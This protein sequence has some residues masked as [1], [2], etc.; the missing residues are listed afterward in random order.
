MRAAGIQNAGKSFGRKTTARRTLKT[1]QQTKNQQPSKLRENNMIKKALFLLM[2]TAMP[3]T[4]IAREF[5]YDNVSKKF[6]IDAEYFAFEASQKL[7]KNYEKPQDVNLILLPAKNEKFA[8]NIGTF[9]VR[10]GFTVNGKTD[11]TALSYTFDF[12]DKKRAYLRLELSDGK[13]I[14]VVRNLGA[15][16]FAVPAT[17]TEERIVPE[18]KEQSKAAQ[19][20]LSEIKAETKAT[21]PILPV[22]PI[23]PQAKVW[24]LRQGSLMNQLDEWAKGESWKLIWQANYDL[25]LNA[26]AS[27][28]GDFIK[29]VEQVFSSLPRKNNGLR[30]SIYKR[31][32]V[33]EVIGE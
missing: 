13:H 9:L 14:G 30:V 20:A 22:K 11:G 31:N 26:D 33:V 4:G 1:L 17:A 23:P 18:Q 32:K 12:I 5:S 29:V 8:D 21:T 10:S 2:L 28:A 25:D 24:V 15:S 6:P 3:F 19:T 16:S 7:A 27:F